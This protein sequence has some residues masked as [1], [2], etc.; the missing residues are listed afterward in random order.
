MFD[1]LIVG[2]GPVGACAAA[3]LTGGSAGSLAPLRVCILEPKRPQPPS[4]GSA[5]EARVVAVSRASERILESAGAWTRV[6]G[7]R[8]AAYERMRIWHESTSP[9]S[10]LVFDAADVGEPN[11][12]YIVENRL[13]QA[14]LLDEF[15]ASGGHMESAELR[16]LNVGPDAVT[17]DTSNGTLTARLVVGADGAKSAVRQAVGL[18]ADIVDFN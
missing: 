10:A 9:A 4:V 18:T 7:P 15:G 8:V 13:L 3:L 1:V 2:G 6:L 5:L 12:G 11:L 16:A 14:A 17:V